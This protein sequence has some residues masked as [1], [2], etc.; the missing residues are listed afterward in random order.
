MIYEFQIPCIVDTKNIY[1]TF[2]KTRYID[3][4]TIP[5]LK[6]ISIQRKT[7][8]E[9]LK[10]LTALRLEEAIPYNLIDETIAYAEAAAEL[11][12]NLL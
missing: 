6:R 4:Q 1:K 8:K 12:V 5:V 9:T 3:K 7:I 10:R 2:A 11:V